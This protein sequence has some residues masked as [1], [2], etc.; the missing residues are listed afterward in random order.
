M[1]PVAGSYIGSPARFAPKNH[2]ACIAASA[3]KPAEPV[4]SATASSDCTRESAP[5]AICTRSVGLGNQPLSGPPAVSRVGVKTAA[6]AIAGA[7][8]ARVAEHDRCLGERGG[9]LRAPRV[10][11]AAR[12]RPGQD[13]AVRPRVDRPRRH[14]GDPLGELAHARHARRRRPAPPRPGRPGPSTASAEASAP[15]TISHAGTRMPSDSVHSPYLHEHLPVHGVDRER[16]PLLEE[17]GE[18]GVGVLRTRHSPRRAPRSCAPASSSV[19]SRTGRAAPPARRTGSGVPSGC[20][21]STTL[22][23]FGPSVVC[24]YVSE[25]SSSYA[26]SRLVSAPVSSQ[27]RR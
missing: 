4:A 25:R 11:H 16:Q 20:I 15:S 10:P 5:Y 8:R 14:R 7:A 26:L 22:P 17:G 27:C 24:R 2:A 3:S 1:I 12:L 19:P 13:R 21:H 18:L 6:S 23:A 9:H